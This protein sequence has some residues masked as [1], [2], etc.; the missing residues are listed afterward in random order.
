MPPHPLPW[1]YPLLMAASLAAGALLSRRGLKRAGLPPRESTL[2]AFGAFFGAVIGAKATILFVDP[3]A[4]WRVAD[5]LD[6]GKTILGGILGGYFGVELVK[7]ARG[8]TVKT[9]DAYAVA[10]AAS[11]AIGR[12]GCYVAGCCYGTPTRLPW[13]VD[14]GDGIARHPT[15]L[16]EA[17]FHGTMAV[18]LYRLGRAGRLRFQLMKLYILSYL[19][20][21][22]ATEYIRPEPRLWG[23]L[24][25]YQVLA[26][27]MVPLFVLL[28]VRDERAYG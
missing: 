24:T 5:L 13:G 28:W 12:L 11:I 21:R 4:S 15:Q 14:F 1:S 25:G 7:W 8:I 16:Y 22:F 26:A 20:Y 10:V 6:G 19:L 3:R 2:L 27:A 23:A 17:A 9:G 18:V